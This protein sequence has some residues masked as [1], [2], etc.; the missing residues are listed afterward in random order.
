MID[1][2]FSMCSC[3]ILRGGNSRIILAPDLPT[4]NLFSL[5]FSSTSL[6]GTLHLIP[7]I[8]PSPCTDSI[9]SGYL[10]ASCSIWSRKICPFDRTDFSS[11]SSSTRSRTALPTAAANGCSNRPGCETD[12]YRETPAQ[13]FGQ[14][15]DVRI[16][17]ISLISKQIA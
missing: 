6:L 3:E 4:S 8:N 7:I 10:L 12:T 5:S 2:D 11:P 15:H 16:D 17:A 1:S 13:T 9:A 14:C